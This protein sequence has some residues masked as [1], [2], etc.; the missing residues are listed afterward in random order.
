MALPG[1]TGA[2]AKP[3]AELSRPPWN[4]FTYGGLAPTRSATLPGIISEN[5]PKP[6]RNTDPGA[7]SQAIAVRGCHNA[8]WVDGKR[9]VR[10][11]SI[12]ALTGS[13][14]SC[15]SD[16]NDPG[17]RAISACGFSG[18]ELCAMRT[19]IVQVTLAVSLMESCAYRS[20]F[21]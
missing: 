12:A 16:A 18:L 17:R 3:P 9:C 6:V 21:R 8:H 10:P 5:T 15:G 1:T 2:T 13:S 19:P 20:M 4:A 14:A 7:N 11:V